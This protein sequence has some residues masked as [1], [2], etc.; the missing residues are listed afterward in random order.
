MPLSDPSPWILRFTSRFILEDAFNTLLDISELQFALEVST[1]D[2]DPQAIQQ[3]L[4]GLSEV[5][6]GKG[7]GLICLA[8]IRKPFTPHHK[9]SFF[10][11][12]R[13]S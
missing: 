12:G 11:A 9:C 6:Q 8:N 10:F 4:N 7:T 5:S 3:R 1:G 13:G 2:A